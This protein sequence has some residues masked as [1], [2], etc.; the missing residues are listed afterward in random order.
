MSKRGRQQSQQGHQGRHQRQQM[1]GRRQSSSHIPWQSNDWNNQGREWN[2]GG[3]G[4]GGEWETD[5]GRATYGSE[6]SRDF[7]RS[8]QFNEG[9][10]GPRD[11]ERDDYGPSAY[12]YFNPSS[13]GYGSP[14]GGYQG[15]RSR[16]GHQNDY[17]SGG[18]GSYRSQGFGRE[19][20]GPREFGQHGYEQ[21]GYPERG[22]PDRGY[23]QGGYSQGGYGQRRGYEQGGYGQ[24]EFGR[25]DF[26]ERQHEQGEYG[27]Y[28][29]QYWRGSGG[30]GPVSRGS[31]GETAQWS[32]HAGRGPKDYQ[33]S[34]ERIRED[35]CDRLT[36]DPEVDATEVTVEARNG[37]VT[38]NGSVHSRDE[39]RAAESCIEQVPGV[40][41]VINQLR[42]SPMRGS[43]EAGT[44]S[45]AGGRAGQTH[46]S[47]KGSRSSSES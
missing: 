13:G 39:K 41:E 9:P 44:G 30:F 12:R 28:G 7:G 35:V 45:G 5:E 2:D 14:G 8:S 22:Y 29:Q 32:G 23:G 11:F 46:G 10:Y 1:Q 21:G 38:L 20:Y 31:S 16:F 27:P 15:S 17:W 40:R 47:G 37:E 43:D 26:G 4:G 34:D 42:V 25:R 3:I 36:A 33:R 6:G 18:Q 19:D 24:R